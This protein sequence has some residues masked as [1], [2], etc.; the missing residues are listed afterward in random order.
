VPPQRTLVLRITTE[1][2]FAA[3]LD[4][5]LPALDPAGS[6]APVRWS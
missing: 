3:P 4:L 6:S 2:A 1:P 5:A